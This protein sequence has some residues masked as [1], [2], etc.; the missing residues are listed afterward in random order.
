MWMLLTAI[1]L[2]IAHIAG[3]NIAVVPDMAANIGS[4][5]Y[6]TSVFAY[7]LFG[8]IVAGLAAWIG[9]KTG[10]ELTCVVKRLFGYSGK[11]VMAI[12]ILS[13]CLPASALTGGYFAGWILFTVTGIP[14]WLG[15]PICIITFSLLAAGYGKELLKISNYVALLLVPILFITLYGYGVPSFRNVPMGGHV[16]WLL[17]CALIGYNVGGM[18]PALVVE[19]AAQLACQGYKAIAMVVLAK[20]F[21]G[22]ITLAAA[23]V[24]LITGSQGPLALVQAVGHFWGAFGMLLF[25][26]ILLCAF[27][28]TMAPAML[29]NAK[30]ISILTGL[31]YWPAM[32]FAGA[33]VGVCSFVRFDIILQLMSYTGVIMA[34][35]IGY[36]VYFLHKYGIK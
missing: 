12:T 30:Q 8:S 11:K 32:C 1:Y 20:L 19:A 26:F 4:D 14:L 33:A 18:R 7:I 5:I 23:H 35:F 27:I 34:V 3:D 28:N 31:S 6:I 24:I 17:V 22:V 15:M 36:T 2:A 21:E 10:L 9:V 25:N 16:D 29:V 13:I